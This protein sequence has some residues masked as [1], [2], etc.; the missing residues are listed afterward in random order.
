LRPLDA[1]LPFHNETILWPRPSV[2]L[3]FSFHGTNRTGFYPPNLPSSRVYGLST[4]P[5]GGV[6]VPLIFLVLVFKLALLGWTSVWIFFS[7]ISRGESYRLRRSPLSGKSIFFFLPRKT[8]V[9]LCPSFLSQDFDFFRPLELA[10]PIFLFRN[11]DGGP[12]YDD[13]Y[14]IYPSPLI[15]PLYTLTPFPL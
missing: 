14:D 13:C 4:L 8:R 3:F 2:F 15:T 10:N 5:G 9:P 7:L 6:T 1:F 12:F 11:L